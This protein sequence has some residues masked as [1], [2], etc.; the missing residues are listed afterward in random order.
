MQHCKRFGCPNVRYGNYDYC[1]RSCAQG[2]QTCG[3]GCTSVMPSSHSTVS[4]ACIKCNKFQQLY[5]YKTCCR[6]CDLSNGRDHGVCCSGRVVQ[7]VQSTRST[8]SNACIKCNKFQQ[9]YPYKTCCR[10]CDLSNGRDH[11]VCCSG[12][13]VQSVQST[14]VI[15]FYDVGKPYYEFTNFYPSNF[16]V[17]GQW[18]RFAEQYF[19]YMKFSQTRPDVAQQILCAS[20]ARSCFD[21]AKRYANFAHPN[22]HSGMKNDV[23]RS[24]LIYKFG[25][26]RNLSTMLLGTKGCT[27]IEDSPIDDYWGC[28]ANGAGKN[29]LGLL[30]MEIRD[31]GFL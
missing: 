1:C 4:N 10:T 7:S 31:G 11:G 26:N 5:P 2:S 24:A 8:V 6:T 22:W 21:I 12:R 3:S 20:N 30:L 25:Q 27:L 9:L 28:G 16:C 18:F 17:G 23:M 15:K 29:M 14:R 13:V 19:Q